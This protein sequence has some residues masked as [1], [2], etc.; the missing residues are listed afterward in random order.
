MPTFD[1]D[2][3]NDA[4]SFALTPAQQQRGR[5]DLSRRV[6]TSVGTQFTAPST[7]SAPF[8]ES[9]NLHPKDDDEFALLSAML[10]PTPVARILPRFQSRPS[11]RKLHR[12]TGEE[13]VFHKQTHTFKAPIAD[14]K[15]KS[16]PFHDTKNYRAS[17]F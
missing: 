11:I 14:V 6:C 1:T 15:S 8:S 5:L 17:K 12:K 3:R 9:G 4:A 7:L 16:R 2:S 13:M 10:G